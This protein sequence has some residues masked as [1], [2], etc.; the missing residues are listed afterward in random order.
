MRVVGKQYGEIALAVETDSANK[1]LH[2][3]IFQKLGEAKRPHL[4]GGFKHV[5]LGQ[6]FVSGEP[7]EGCRC[8]RDSCDAPANDAR[9][10]SALW[11]QLLIR[12]EDEI[13]NYGRIY[14]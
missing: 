2:L 5:A 12:L 1:I 3:W 14:W 7:E 10:C 8:C 4:L 13:N 11:C 9:D 6:W